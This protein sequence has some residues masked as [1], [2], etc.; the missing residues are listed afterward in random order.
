MVAE[1]PANW[2][3]DQGLNVT[4][5]ILTA[6][7]DLKAIF[8]ENDEMAFGAA[9]ALKAAGKQGRILLVGYNG[10]C[11]GLQATINGTFQAEGIL[12]DA[13]NARVLVQTALAYHQGKKVPPFVETPILLLDTAQMKAILNGTRKEDVPG[14]KPR[15]IQANA[16]K[17]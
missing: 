16:G 15:L 12:F 1:Q 13:L 8:A 3:R 14:L 6:N 5:N 11:I 17:C 7:P 10:T 9:A 2:A 4:T